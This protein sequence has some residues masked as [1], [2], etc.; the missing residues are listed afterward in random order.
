VEPRCYRLYVSGHGRDRLHNGG[1]ISTFWGSFTAHRRYFAETVETGSTRWRIKGAI[2]RQYTY[3]SSTTDPDGDSLNYRFD[4]GD[5]TY[6]AWA[7]PYASGGIARASH[8]WADTGSYK[9]KVIARDENGL[10]SEWSDELTVAISEYLCGDA[11]QDGLIEIGDVVYL[12]NYT[13][14]GGPAPAPLA[15]GDCNCDGNI[16][17][18]DVVLIINYLFNH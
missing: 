3:T 10:F 2:G 15:S 14:K 12:I 8:E 16:D 1:G 6:S 7:G 9:I 17:L 18:D 13:L 11:N 5:E 4:W